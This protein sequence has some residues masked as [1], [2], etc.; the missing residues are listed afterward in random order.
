MIT[1]IR[2]VPQDISLAEAKALL[3]QA[4]GTREEALLES[5]VP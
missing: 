2:P 5:G 1:R 4:V 3:D